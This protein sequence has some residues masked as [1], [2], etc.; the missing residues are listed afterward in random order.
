[1]LENAQSVRKGKIYSYNRGET[2]LL[3]VLNAQRTYNDIQQS[4][5]ETLFNRAVAL[6]ALEK[7]AGIWD[8]SF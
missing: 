6:V 4:Y 5:Y 8:I 1:L 3:E 7:A 2:S